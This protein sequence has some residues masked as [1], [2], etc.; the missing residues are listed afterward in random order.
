MADENFNPFDE[1]EET[2]GDTTE[3]TETTEPTE[4]NGTSEPTEATEPAETNEPSDEE[5]VEPE[6]YTIEQYLYDS[7]NFSVPENAVK[8]ILKKR[9][10]DGSEEYDPEG[11]TSGTTAKLLYADLLKW[12][13]LGPSRT[14]RVSDSDNGWSH[15]EGG[16][17][18]SKDDKKLL[19]NEANAIYEELEPESKFGKRRIKMHSMGI[20]PALRDLDGE[21]LP[22]GR[23]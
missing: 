15:S 12:I 7:V 18:L 17:T 14:N 19:M 4:N 6:V 11:E 3:N 8:S 23:R 13:C 16:Y 20:M 5:P 10:V 2:S 1:Q 22:R 21:P 9:G